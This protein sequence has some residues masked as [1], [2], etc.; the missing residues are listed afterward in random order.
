MQDNGGKKRLLISDDCKFC[1][2][3]KNM[4][5]DEISKGEIELINIKDNK[6]ANYLAGKFGGVPTLI[7]EK[8]GRIYELKLI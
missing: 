1:D 4:L 5:K 8:K 7:E 3:V 6:D 2:I